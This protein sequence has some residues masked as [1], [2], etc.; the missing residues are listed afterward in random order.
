MPLPAPN[1]DDLRFQRDLVDEA[2]RRIIRYC[3]EWTDYNLSDPGITLIE[4]FSWMTEMMVYRLNRVPEKNYV[5]FLELLGIKLQ[6]ASSA[7]TELTFWTSAPFPLT[8]EG[9]TR[10]IVP[11]GLE[12]STESSDEEPEVTFTTDERLIIAPPRLILL[13]REGDLNRNY[14]P[15][16]GI[17]PFYAFHRPRPRQGDAFYLG[18]DEEHDISGYILRLAFECQETT[19]VGIK[20]EDPPWVW[21][22]SMGNDQWREIAPSKRANEK[23]TTGGL[24]NSRGRLVLYLPLD[25]DTSEVN[26]RNAYWI[27]CRLEQRDPKQGMY[28][29]SP[30]ITNVIAQVMGGTAVAT[31]AIVVRNEELGFSDG[32]PGQTFTLEHQPVLTLMEGERVEVQEVRDGEKVFVPWQRVADFSMSDQHDR[33]FVLDEATG[34]VSFGPSIRQPDGTVRQYGRIPPAQSRIRVSKYRH[35]G[36][37]MGNVPAGRIRVMRSAVP[38]ISQVTNL[39]RASGGRDQESLEEAQVRAQREI[40]AQRRAVTAEDFEN[41]GR[42]ASRSIARIKCNTPGQGDQAVLPGS[43]DLL[44]VP[45]AIEAIQAGDLSRLALDNALIRTIRSHLDQYR[46]LTSTLN[47][48]EPHYVGV[49]IHADIVPSEY[50]LPESVVL[51]VREYLKYLITPLSLETENEHLAE[52]L[53]PDWAGW[54]FGKDL[55]VAELYSFIQQVP[56]VKHVLDVQFSYRQV[57]PSQEAVPEEKE[58][59]EEEEQVFEEEELRLAEERILR[60]SPD[61]LLCSLDHAIEVVE[62]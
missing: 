33:H 60:V 55:F 42:T 19:A 45:S 49:K 1:L 6:P 53:G 36:G 3:P 61:T 28:D 37:V 52:I 7:R 14:L 5:K 10:A 8:P 34:E 4:L 58:L 43:I 54:P 39:K 62:L 41:I 40:R 35:G 30:A 2:R 11:Q 17:E 46:L 15:R 21:E 56:G 13:Q 57:I 27:R 31:H 20:R 22:C 12:V 9:E 38:Y 29:Q 59:E 23:D 44:V 25:M 47:I 24:N 32:D 51:R 48:R 50:Q 26:G 18:F 16:L